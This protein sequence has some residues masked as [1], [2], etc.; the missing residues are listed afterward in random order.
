MHKFFRGK[1]GPKLTV[2]DNSNRV[3]LDL[4]KTKETQK[5]SEEGTIGQGSTWKELGGSRGGI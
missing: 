2:C 1:G 5:K 3:W 4:R